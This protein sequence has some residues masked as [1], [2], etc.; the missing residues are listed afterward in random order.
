[1]EQYVN[2]PPVYGRHQ[3]D[4]VKGVAILMLI[5]HHLFLF[6]SSNPWFTGVF[7]NNWGGIEFFLSSIG[8][9]CIPF[10]F[11]VSGYGLWMS[12]KGE[13]S[14]WKKTFV[15]VKNLYV[16][17][18]V[19][20]FVT[21]LLL[22][23][24]DGVFPLHSLRQAVETF[25]G[26]NVALNG[27]WWFFIVYVELLLLTPL[28]VL[29]VQ[30][31]SWQIFL[32]LSFFLYLFSAPVSGFPY[33]AS[34]LNDAGLEDLLYTYFPLNLFWPNQFYFFTGFCLAASG[35]F[36][37]GLQRGLKIGFFYRIAFALLLI[38]LIL[39]FRYFFVDICVL[40]GLLS[41]EGMDIFQYT[42]IT[43]RVDFILG[44]VCLFS[45]VLLFY[46]HALPWLCFLGRQS[47]P[48]WLIHGSIIS[49]VTNLLKP[50]HVWS[51]LVFFTVLFPCILY[52]LLYRGGSQLIARSVQRI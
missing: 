36:E 13:S 45:L 46:G 49:I 12:S 51:P 41:K 47:A 40:F 44:P 34:L 16:I 15:R 3:A 50:Y 21:V 10:F 29:L 25:L 52:A 33:L 11:F 39:L 19:T 8:K 4:Q 32:G 9:L 22:Y 48:I 26:V 17:Y 7:G 18:V 30:R 1:M 42:T 31:F 38:T 14:L 5:L 23:L 20:V 43:T 24:W 2:R 35:Y 37:Q 28:A 27:S 6:P